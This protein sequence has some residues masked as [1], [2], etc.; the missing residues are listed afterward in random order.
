MYNHRSH[1][2][3]KENICTNKDWMTK[4]T[5]RENSCTQQ[6]NYI[7]ENKDEDTMKQR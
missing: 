5:K 7:G 4:R 6:Q 3:S 1:E 2:I